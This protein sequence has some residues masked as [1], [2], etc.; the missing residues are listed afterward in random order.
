MASK[1]LLLLMK[2]LCQ[3]KP[4]AIRAQ[5]FYLESQLFHVPGVVPCGKSS[6]EFNP[7]EGLE[8]YRLIQIKLIVCIAAVPKGTHSF[9]KSVGFN[10]HFHRSL[11][12]SSLLNSIERNRPY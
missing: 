11:L 5:A 4:A 6:I 3:G 2:L 1:G 12:V 10:S 9:S 7:P 8:F